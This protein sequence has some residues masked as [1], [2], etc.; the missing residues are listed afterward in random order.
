MT[1]GHCMWLV[2][3]FHKMGSIHE[4]YKKYRRKMSK[5]QGEQTNS[6]AI[7]APPIPLPL[8]IKL[9]ADAALGIMYL[10]SES[11]IHR[12][13]FR[14]AGFPLRLLMMGMYISQTLQRAT[15][16]W[17]V[18]SNPISGLSSLTLV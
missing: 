4:F 1:T 12:G 15:C 16:L 5:D 11:V 14:L 18:P 6:A 2:T 8:V 7:S 13:S 17:A 10:H 3:E 9:A